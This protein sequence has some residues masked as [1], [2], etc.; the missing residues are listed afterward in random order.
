MMPLWAMYLLL[1]LGLGLVTFV[2]YGW[3]KYKSKRDG[4][5]T[6]EKTLHWMALGGGWLG[7]ILG[8]QYFRHKTRKRPFLWITYG[9]TLLHVVVIGLLIRGNL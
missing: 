2:T 1:V 5:R 6:P 3:D 4:W 9:I 8:Q 7:A